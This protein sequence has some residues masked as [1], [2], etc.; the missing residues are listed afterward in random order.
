[1]HDQRNDDSNTWIYYALVGELFKTLLP[2]KDTVYKDSQN[3]V[4]V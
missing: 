2:Q 3:Q 1:M 4:Q